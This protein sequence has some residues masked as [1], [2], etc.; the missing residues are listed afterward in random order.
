MADD[1]EPDTRP[2]PEV[3]RGLSQ[4]EALLGHQ[5]P[6]GQR[7]RETVERLLK[8]QRSQPEAAARALG[9]LSR[10]DALRAMSQEAAQSAL[11]SSGLPSPE[12]QASLAVRDQVRELAQLS[13]ET[14]ENIAELAAIASTALEQVAE[15]QAAAGEVL[16][17]S[18][19]LR[20]TMTVASARADRAGSLTIALTVVLAALTV[21]L[22]ILTYVLAADQLHWWPFVG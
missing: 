20:A 4:M 22:V 16:E 7:L 9:A 6:P 2:P 3:P 8:L 5:M 15:I 14:S 12:T 17:E 1:P 18:K 13:R 19:A 10:S 11:R 21:A